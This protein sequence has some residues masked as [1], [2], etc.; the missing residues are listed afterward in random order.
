MITGN[1]NTDTN[2]YMVCQTIVNF[3][4]YQSLKQINM[5]KNILIIVFVVIANLLAINSIAQTPDIG[6]FFTQYQMVR[7]HDST[8][9]ILADETTISTIGN[10]ARIEC[11]NETVYLKLMI[12]FK[13]L[14]IRHL[15]CNKLHKGNTFY[16]AILFVNNHDAEVIK[17]WAKNNL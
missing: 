1:Q 13:P 17:A 16:R 5:K 10:E 3:I 15:V 8:I 4:N 2:S 11:Y 7:S 12:K 14:V 9:T 6:N